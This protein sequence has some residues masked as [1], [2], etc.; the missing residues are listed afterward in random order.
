LLDID[1]DGVTDLF[2]QEESGQLELFQ[3][4]S[5]GWHLTGERFQGIDIG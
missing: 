4:A 3:H 2:I 1:G 5:D